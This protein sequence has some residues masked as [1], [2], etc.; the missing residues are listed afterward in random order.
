MIFASRSFDS[1]RDRFCANAGDAKRKK[2]A[3]GNKNSAIAAKLRAIG[4]SD[5]K[6]LVPG[7]VR[8]HS[9]AGACGVRGLRL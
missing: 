7:Q 8:R 4:E 1:A 9:C 5:S 2:A 3:V 6:L